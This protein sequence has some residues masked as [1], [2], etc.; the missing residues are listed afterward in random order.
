MK[1]DKRYLISAASAIA[2]A[3]ALPSTPAAAQAA[4]ADPTVT[5]QP[6]PAEPAPVASPAPTVDIPDATD[7]PAATG[8]SESV[9]PVPEASTPAPDTSATT[10]TTRTVTP[11]PVVRN[12]THTSTT[13]TTTVTRTAPVAAPVAAVPVPANDAALPTDTALPPDT[14]DAVPPVAANPGAVAQ[15]SEARGITGTMGLLALA[16]LA[17]IIA[18]VAFMF[19]RRRSPVTTQIVETPATT[20]TLAEPVAVAEPVAA[21]PM[22]PTPIR[23][24][25]AP[26]R[27]A[28]AS[29]G[30]SVDLPAQQPESY[31]ERSAL[32]DKMVN[33]KPDKANPFTD[34][35]QR[36]H[37]ARLIMQSLGVTFDREPRI[38]LS[39]YPNN[40]PELQRQYHKAA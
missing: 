17:L 30:A 29:A 1:H 38:D 6:L 32:L 22:T 8:A 39:Q 21:S 19:F 11:A 10:T 20:S 3:L 23:R 35:R 36:M 25:T 15:P 14:T 31:E 24:D 27:G 33:A 5:A 34:R 12:T 7:A 37:R 40:W 28:L 2:A 16:V 9:Q 4:P 13:R 26:V 18:G